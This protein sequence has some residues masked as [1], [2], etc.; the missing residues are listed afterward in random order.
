MRSAL[1]KV[2]GISDIETNISER[3]CSFTAPADLDVEAVLNKF[4]E[5][6]NEHIAGWAKADEKEEA[7]AKSDGAATSKTSGT[8]TVSLKLPGMT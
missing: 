2:D 3:S 7:P 8:Q 1:T 5:E 4:A 6:G